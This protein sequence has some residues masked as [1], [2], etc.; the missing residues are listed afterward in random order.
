M[1]VKCMFK[2]KLGHI[3][4]TIIYWLDSVI[5]CIHIE[6]KRMKTLHTIQFTYHAYGIIILIYFQEKNHSDGMAE[7]LS[8][9]R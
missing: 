5:M 4:S 2:I 9:N 3:P 8:L 6:P 1:I 7:I